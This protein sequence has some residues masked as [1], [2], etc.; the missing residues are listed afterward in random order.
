MRVLLGG[1]AR[2]GGALPG[3]SAPRPV[4]SSNGCRFLCL[5]L[6]V[7]SAGSRGPRIRRG[8]TVEALGLG[9]AQVGDLPL[10]QL[11]ALQL[12]AGQL[13]PDLGAVAE[14]ELDPD[15]EAEG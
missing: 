9:R 3:K 13:R 5:V 11:Q 1:A 10:A 14:H 2:W 4:A 15:L 6:V 7:R 12:V 8:R